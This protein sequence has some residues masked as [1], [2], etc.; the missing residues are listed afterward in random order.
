VNSGLVVTT[1]TAQAITPVAIPAR[2]TFDT[3]NGDG[4]LAGFLVTTATTNAGAITNMT[5]SYTNSAGVAGRT[6]T[7][8]SFPATAVIGSFI[9]VNLQAGDKGIQS[10]QSVT[11]GTSLAAGAVSLVLYRV[12]RQVG[13]LAAYTIP[14]KPVYQAP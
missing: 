6:G 9:P 2:D 13:I 12:V 3:A 8:T 4:V 14:P 11:F 5:I 7:V 10:V 1:T